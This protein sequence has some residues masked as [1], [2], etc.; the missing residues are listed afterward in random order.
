MSLSPCHLL[1]WALYPST[2]HAQHLH[3]HV[4]HGLWLYFYLDEW[5]LLDDGYASAWAWIQ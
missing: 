2:E 5:N 1:S 3:V 4:S